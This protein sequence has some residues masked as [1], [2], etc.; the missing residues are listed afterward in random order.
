M[1]CSASG[2]AGAVQS[3]TQL[4]YRMTATIEAS[5]VFTPNDPYYAA[6][7]ESSK[8]WV[9]SKHAV[10][11]SSDGDDLSFRAQA[12]GKIV[13]YGYKKTFAKYLLGTQK[14]ECPGFTAIDISLTRWLDAGTGDIV[15]TSA[16]LLGVSL[17]LDTSHLAKVPNKIPH[18]TCNDPETGNVVAETG[19]N[20]PCSTYIDGDMMTGGWSNENLR[21][22]ERSLEPDPIRFGAIAR[23]F[24]KSFEVSGVQGWSRKGPHGHATKH[25]HYTLYF[26]LCGHDGRVAAGC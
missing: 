22:Y 20:C 11:V 15:T 24:G 13:T 19:E 16:R 5:Y 7:T 9:E 26:K 23:K 25:V 2:T 14:I 1:A 10:V 18:W 8:W 21:P 3:P 6:I 17:G 4:W 12:K